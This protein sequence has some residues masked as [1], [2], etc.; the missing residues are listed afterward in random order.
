MKLSELSKKENKRGES[1][2]GAAIGNCIHVAGP[3]NFLDLAEQEG[4][5]TIFLGPRVA[6]PKLIREV[7]HL[8]PDLVA[9]SY[10]LTPENAKVLFGELKDAIQQ[11][12]LGSKKFIF[13]GTAPV[14]AVARETGIFDAVFSG[15]ESREEIVSYLKGI[16]VK[17]KISGKYPEDLPSAI[18]SK[19]PVPLIRHHLGLPSLKDTVEAASV[20]AQAGVLD[21]LSIAPDQNAQEYFFNPTKMD[22]GLDGSGGVPIRA[23]KDLA[24]IYSA[25]RCGN[26]PLVRCYAGTQDLIKWANML[27]ETINVAWGAVPLTWYSQLDGRSERPPLAALKENM[28]AIKWYAQHGIPV[29]VNESHQWAVR[30]TSDIIEVATAFLASYAAK[31]LGVKWYVMQYMFNTPADISPQMDLAKMLAK[32]ELIEKLQDENF[33][34]YRMVRTGLASLP[35]NP[36]V[37]K[38]QLA[39]STTISMSLQ[40]HIIHVV[41]YSEG[42]YAATASVIMESCEIVTGVINNCLKGLPDIHSNKTIHDRKQELVEQATILLEAISNLADEEI[43]DPW[44]DP[45]T[46]TEAIKIGLLDAPHLKG[47]AWAKGCLE[48][49][50]IDG[51]CHAINTKTKS[52]LSEKDRITKILIGYHRNE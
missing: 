43:S 44:I 17:H 51:A 46:L 25:T 7:K 4:Y 41:G 5:N 49:K 34:C 22:S 27:R 29:E 38:G 1:I 23:P 19:Y 24:S 45:G 31:Q 21:I 33:T 12:G 52:I 26:Y 48:T 42:D 35:A 13:G 28:K 10:R 11:H 3:V 32:I 18:D 6:I 2:L 40:P 15:I 47:N 36:N 39:S 14:A 50:I 37:A 20:I 30:N 9:V 8:N 16:Q